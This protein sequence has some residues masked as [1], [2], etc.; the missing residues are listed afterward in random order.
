MLGHRPSI[1]DVAQR[2][3]TN[4]SERAATIKHDERDRTGKSVPTDSAACKNRVMPDRPVTA[5]ITYQIDPDQVEEFEAYGRAWIALVDRFGGIHH[6]YFLPSEG[7]SNTA[8]ALFT[9]PSLAAYERYRMEA[10][11]DPECVS[12]YERARACGCVLSFTRT[13]LRPVLTP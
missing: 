7:S 11:T 13:F 9:F 8:Y 5:H 12:V 3:A 10:E 1:P 2:L 4:R 6:G